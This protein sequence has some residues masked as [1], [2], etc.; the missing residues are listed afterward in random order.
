MA[1]VRGE[2]KMKKKIIRRRLGRKIGKG[3]SSKA[4]SI[5]E[6]AIKKLKGNRKS[7]TRL[8]EAG[9]RVRAAKENTGA[10]KQVGDNVDK[11]LAKSPAAIASRKEQGN[12]AAD[13]TQPSMGTLGMTADAADA[14]IRSSKFTAKKASDFDKALKKKQKQLETYETTRDSLKGVDKIKFISKNQTM[15]KSLKASIKDMKSRGG[16]GGQSKIRYKKKAG[17]P[18]V[19]KMGGGSLKDIPAGNKGLSKLPKGVRKKIGFKK[20][21]GPVSKKMGGGKVYKYK[22]GTGNKTIMSMDSKTVAGCY[23]GFK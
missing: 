21:G 19:K 20:A 7:A 16:P 5:A 3:G 10:A 1:Q 4:T 23:P 6:E 13:P 22:H 17:G 9:Q 2:F 15:V 11:K 18:V 8:N 14:N 12:A